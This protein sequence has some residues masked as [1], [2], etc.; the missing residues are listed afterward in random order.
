[1]KQENPDRQAR[2]LDVPLLALNVVLVVFTAAILIWGNV[3]YSDRVRA[4]TF[5][6]NS[7]LTTEWR[8]LK[9]MK[10]RTD[11]LLQDKDREIAALRGQYDRLQKSSASLEQLAELETQLRRAESEREGILAARYGAVAAAAVPQASEL[12]EAVDAGSDAMNPGPDGPE[13]ADSA[14]DA[15]GPAEA[16][17]LAAAPASVVSALVPSDDGPVA[18][19]LKERIRS[20]EV[21]LAAGKKDEAALEG[22]VSSLRRRLDALLAAGASPG[23]GVA[24]GSPRV[25]EPGAVD[26]LEN[27]IED[28]KLR[29]ERALAIHTPGAAAAAVSDGTPPVPPTIVPPIAAAP[30]ASVPGLSVPDAPAPS[31]PP[32]QAAPTLDLDAVLAALQRGRSALTSDDPALSLEDIKTRS[33]LRAIVR[34]PAIR[35]EYPSLAAALDR[36]FE[37]YGAAERRKGEAVAYDE[38]IAAMKA[39]QE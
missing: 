20:L 10:E 13:A 24:A 31:L 25:P 33:L 36:Y 12:Q 1:M 8:L 23:A 11:R 39:L 4:A 17:P 19:L 3:Y 18:Q 9:E 22:E 5:K 28:L 27:E 26:A 35:S 29:L 21:E 37:L 2:R 6:E 32:E 15:S 34:T 16:G 38:A 14:R 7:F 30:N